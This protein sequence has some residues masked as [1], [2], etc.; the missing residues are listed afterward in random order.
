METVPNANESRRPLL[1]AQRLWPGR[2]TTDR[3]VLLILGDVLA[4]S[5]AV[6]IALRLWT[7]TGGQRFGWPFVWNNLGWIAL[8]VP[9]WLLLNLD[10]HA[11][12]VSSTW[13]AMAGRFVANTSLALALYAIVFFV[14]PRGL[15]PRLMILYFIGGALLLNLAWRRLYVALFA[16]AFF[17]RPALVVGAGWAGEV[18]VEALARSQLKDYRVV[19]FIDDDPKKQGRVIAGVPVLGG[20]QALL[21]ALRA[22]QGA[23]VILA[24]KGEL[25]AA[26]FQTL[27]ECQALGVPVVRM[28]A[29]YEQVTGRV[30][31]EH[32]DADLMAASFNNDE[33]TLRSWFD[34]RKRVIDVLGGLAGLAVM[35]CLLPFVAAAIRIESPGPVFYRQVRLGRSGRL[36]TLYKFRTMVAEAEADGQARWADPNDDRVTRVGRWLRR[37]RLDEMPQ[38]W[39]VLLGDM[40]LVGPRPERPEFIA[41][42]EHEIPFYSARHLVKPGIT[43]WA[44]INYGY[45]ATVADAAVKL[46]WDLY[47]IKHRSAW[48]DMMILV[49]T[50]GVVLA[51]KGT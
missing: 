12:Q 45:S 13:M 30:P 16:S 26:T 50:V 36:F 38:F 7:L 33:V 48:L 3:R 27:L 34:M 42:L 44:Q 39:N 49:R 15:L 20:R 51:G 14:A 8:L 2:R 11:P 22:Q 41:A 23:E 47:Y 1:V 19:G 17:R 28:A 21:P 25:Q 29:L 40:S 37:Y 46:Q 31:L 9:A 43:G 6:L 10:L 5:A 4:T 32:V 18:L 35:L 24:I